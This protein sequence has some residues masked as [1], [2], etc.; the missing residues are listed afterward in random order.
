[1]TPT[2][3]FYVVH[4]FYLVVSMCLLFGMYSNWIW[5]ASSTSRERNRRRRRNRE[6]SHVLHVYGVAVDYEENFFD[7]EEKPKDTVDWRKEGF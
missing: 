2:I 6:A 4:F 5:S 3:I 7:D 1:M